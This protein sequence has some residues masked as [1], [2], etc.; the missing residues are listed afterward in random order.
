[1]TQ[2]YLGKELEAFELGHG[3][4]RILW[5][6][7]RHPGAKQKDVTHHF[8]LDKGST[9]TLISSLEKNGFVIREKDT[10]DSRAVCLIPTDRAMALQPNLREVFDRWT[11]RLLHGFSGEERL[12][13]IDLLERMIWN[14]DPEFYKRH[15]HGQA[16]I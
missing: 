14:A 7:F 11:V 12:L 5:Y 10:Q 16:K 15:H 13:V 4:V 3:Q 9:S 1:M 6:L 8:K 2:T